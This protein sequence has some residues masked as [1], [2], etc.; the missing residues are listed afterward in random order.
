CYFEQIVDVGRDQAATEQALVALRDVQ[1]RFP[2]SE[3]AVDA[4]YKLDMV[5]DQLAGKEMEVGRWYL[6]EGQTI[7][8]IGRFRTVIDK[9][10]TTSHA[11]EA[12][13]RLVEAYLTVGL[14][15]EAERTGGMLGYNFR[16]DVWYGEAY[17]LLTDK[18]LQP[19]VAPL[20]P[21]SKRSLLQRLTG[22]GKRKA[23]PP[24]AETNAPASAPVEA[25]AP[26]PSP[27]AP[28]A[29]LETPE[30]QPPVTPPGTEPP[31]PTADPSAETPTP[32]TR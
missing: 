6:R 3:Y 31:P 9:Y 20:T 1:L 21:G 17:K 11:P 4:Q 23:I 32:P 29:P 18:G 8:A 10:Q 25:N 5:Y 19:A 15:G 12:L 14:V 24:P 26:A 13:Y 28:G 2:K 22:T 16:D 27:A 7:A 30:P